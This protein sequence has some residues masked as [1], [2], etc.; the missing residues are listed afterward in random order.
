[1]ARIPTK[2][3][4]QWATTADVARH[5]GISTRRFRELRRQWTDQGYCQDGKHYV[6]Y[7]ARLI[8]FD[9]DKMD[10]LARR[11]GRIIQDQ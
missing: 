6:Q 3:P 7:N 11:M 5:L 2:V 8:R 10:A 1:M 9:L 4:H